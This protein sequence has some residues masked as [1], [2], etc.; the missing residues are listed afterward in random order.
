MQECKHCGITVAGNKRCC[1]LCQGE[2]TGSPEPLLEAFPQQPAPKYDRGLLRKLINFTS[3]FAI[4]VCLVI[5]FSFTRGAVWIF[6]AVAGILSGWLT[7]SVAI[8]FRTRLFKN[9]TC[10]MLIRSILCFIWDHFTG[11]HG[12]S[13]DYVLPLCCETTMVVDV[14]LARILKSEES[15]YMIHLTIA[16]I[17]SL[18]PFVLL[19]LNRVSVPLPSVICSLMAFLLIAALIVFRSRTFFAELSRRMHI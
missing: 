15:E 16:T 14:L 12:W 11:S 9:L 2:L 19:I 13:V 1:P 7:I 5:E 17:Y 3:V 4:A 18:A 6:F 8:R 10:L